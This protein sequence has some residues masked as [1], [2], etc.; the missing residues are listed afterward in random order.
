MSNEVRIL[1]LQARKAVLAA[2]GRDNGNIIKKIE[3]EI[4]NL[5]TA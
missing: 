3:R 1:I 2:R 4:R 5:T